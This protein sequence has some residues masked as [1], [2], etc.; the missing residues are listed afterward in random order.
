MEPYTVVPSISWLRFNF[1]SRDISYA[2]KETSPINSERLVNP[3]TPKEAKTIWCK[4]RKN[5][6]LEKIGEI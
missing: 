2:R 4:S 3:R 1:V 5:I 6:L